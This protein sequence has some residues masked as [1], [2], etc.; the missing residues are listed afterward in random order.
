VK[1][2]SLPAGPFF[3]ADD[4]RYLPGLTGLIIEAAAMLQ[5]AEI[6]EQLLKLRLKRG[7]FRALAMH[8]PQS[9]VLSPQSVNDLQQGG[10]ERFQRESHK[11][12]DVGSNPAP[13]TFSSN[14]K[15]E[16]R[17]GCASENPAAANPAHPEG[18]PESNI[19]DLNSTG[20]G[21]RSQFSSIKVFP[22]SLAEQF[23]TT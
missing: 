12:V 2:I 17:V 11:L 5:R 23:K 8:S 13:A 16:T 9:L 6:E 7:C 3:C 14:G 20:G 15:L 18:K 1:T 21:S 10:L 4:G 22:G 19:G